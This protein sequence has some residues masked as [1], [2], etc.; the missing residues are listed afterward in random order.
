MDEDMFL[1]IKEEYSRKIKSINQE[2]E[3]TEG[4]LSVYCSNSQISQAAH[5]ILKKYSTF[6]ELTNEMAYDFIDFVEIGE[7]NEAGE[8]DV[9]IHWNF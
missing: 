1:R 5:D 3:I 6:T 9:I 7:K 2:I 8:Q 4:K